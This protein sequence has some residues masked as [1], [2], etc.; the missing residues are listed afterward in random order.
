M[1]N[2]PLIIFLIILLSTLSI[3]LLIFMIMAINGNFK[4]SNL[5][6]GYKTSNTL[7]VDETYDNNFE[8]IYIKSDAS[9]IEIKHSEN[10]DIRVIVYGDQ[11][12]TN[13]DAE[14]KNL[15]IKTNMKKCVGICFN[16]T[17]AKIQLYVP[18]NYEYKFEVINSFGDIS[19]EDFKNSQVEVEENCGDVEI[20]GANT[21]VVKNDFGDIS[22]G[23]V[24]EAN[25]NQSAGDVKV[26]FINDI[27][28]VNKLG[29][30]KI[31]KVNNY[32]DLTNNCGDIKVDEINL[33]KDSRIVDDLGDIKIGKTNN[34]YIDAK[35]SLGDVKINNNYNKSD[36]TLNI[37][38]NCGDIK[39]SN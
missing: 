9:D 19:I 26:D 22:L 27:T 3:C 2:K 1:K 4:F 32:L 37:K 34:I 18:E 24:N 20:K 23:E 16:Q 31:K 25:I 5:S 10:N 7:V 6:F 12:K 14:G 30:I 13:V 21:V 36:I 33:N 28:V 35:T 39:V 29:D 15:T 17:V 11:D 8:Y 38:N